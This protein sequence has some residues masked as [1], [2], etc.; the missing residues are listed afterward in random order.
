MRFVVRSA[1]VSCSI[2]R[3]DKK[4]SNHRSRTNAAAHP[5]PPPTRASCG[6]HSQAGFRKTP[7]LSGSP[8]QPRSQAGFR[9]T[10]VLGI[11]A[12]RPQGDLE[13]RPPGRAAHALH[14]IGNHPRTFANAALR[15]RV[16]VSVPVYDVVVHCGQVARHLGL[17]CA[18]DLDRRAYAA[19]CGVWLRRGHV[20]H[21]TRTT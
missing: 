16:L 3:R 13:N 17:D 19:A 7:F 14:R 2:C 8:A 6:P 20:Q 18:Q 15:A 9:T 4:A 1:L 12:S 5:R 10:P 11:R 21:A